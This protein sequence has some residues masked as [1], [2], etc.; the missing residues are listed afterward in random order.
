MTGFGSASA[1]IAGASLVV[2]VKSV[3]HKFCEVKLRLPR[4]LT[5]L[6]VPLTRAVKARIARGALDVIVKLETESGETAPADVDVK[7]LGAYRRAF[8]Q[9]AGALGVANDVGL[10]AYLHLPNVLR[11]RDATLDSAAL[12][13][14][15]QGVVST[16]LQ[17]LV[18]MRTTEGA[19]LFAD[20]TAR[21]GVLNGLAQRIGP[22][23]AKSV[24]EA[25]AR[26]EA[27]LQELGL[28]QGVDPNRVAQEVALL[29]DRSDVSEELTRLDGHLRQFRELLEATEPVGRKLDFLVQ[30]LHREI[31]TTGSKSQSLDLARL[32]IEFKAE[33]E[34]IREQIQNVE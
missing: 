33:L 18:Q 27:R 14:T 23:S 9:A 31:N 25:R 11:V 6:E 17:A 13:P 28:P 12:E 7:I 29:A 15:V 32:V 5:N 26:F 8:E 10:S 3:N 16:A 1:Q 19:A 30:E 24:E 21:L 22:L 4:E 20:L 34:K 2:E